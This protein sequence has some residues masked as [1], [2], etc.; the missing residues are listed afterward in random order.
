VT[1]VPC[2]DVVA[3][4]DPAAVGWRRDLGASGIL[5]A[6][7]ELAVAGCHGNRHHRVLAVNALDWLAWV[8]PWLL[9]HRW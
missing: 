6:P 4:P 8:A 7:T 1:Q 9:E 2:A 5:S 3:T